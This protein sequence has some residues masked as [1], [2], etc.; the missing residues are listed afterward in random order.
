MAQIQRLLASGW[1]Q[2]VGVAGLWGGANI[3][4]NH[5]DIGVLRGELG[6]MTAELKQDMRDNTS[7]LQGVMKGRKSE[8]QGEIKGLKSEVIKGLHDDIAHTSQGLRDD[9]RDDLQRIL[10]K[11]VRC[12]LYCVIL[13][14]G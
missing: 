9:L 6:S 7:E 14:K 11:Q 5:R 8:L 4:F 10:E 13:L 2:A 1:P 12:W 3:F